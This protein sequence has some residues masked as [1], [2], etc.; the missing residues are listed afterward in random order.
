[1]TISLAE[2]LDGLPRHLAMHPCAVVLSDGGLLD[3]APLTLN[4]GGYPMVEF[5]KDDVEAVGLLKL[6]ILGV[7]MQSSISF[8]LSRD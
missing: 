3:R 8:A 5:D 4:A 2:R 7:R 6:D 1:M